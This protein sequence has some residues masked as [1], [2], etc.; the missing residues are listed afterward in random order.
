[1]HPCHTFHHHTRGF[2]NWISAL[3]KAQ[4]SA[5]FRHNCFILALCFFVLGEGGWL[6]GVFFFF[7]WIKNAPFSHPLPHLLICRVLMPFVK[8]SCSL[9]GA[10]EVLSIQ[11]YRSKGHRGPEQKRAAVKL[12]GVGI[13]ELC[14]SVAWCTFQSKGVHRPEEWTENFTKKP[15]KPS[16][17]LRGLCVLISP[18]LA[19]QIF[20]IPVMLIRMLHVK[21]NLHLFLSQ[22]VGQDDVQCIQG[23]AGTSRIIPALSGKCSHASVCLHA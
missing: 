7:T 5:L 15:P 14:A 4:R 16:S 17:H 2:W 20:Q 10:K 13:S 18:T 1:M 19:R 21:I 6:D 3:Q 22:A 12:E 11:G 8:P 23:V 9:S